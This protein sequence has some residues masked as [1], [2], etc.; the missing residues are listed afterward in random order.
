MTEELKK[1][2]EELAAN[3]KEKKKVN[4]HRLFIRGWKRDPS[5]GQPL[6]DRN[7]LNLI[8]DWKTYLVKG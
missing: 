8:T 7:V 3:P 4:T 6:A 1:M 2:K 5:T